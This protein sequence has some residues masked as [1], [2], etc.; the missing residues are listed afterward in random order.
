MPRPIRRCA[1]GARVKFALPIRVRNVANTRE[2]WRSR[3]ARTATE[4]EAVTAGVNISSE[5]DGH[6]WVCLTRVAPRPFDSDGLA[7]SFKAIR[8]Q[9]A[10]LL[11]RDDDTRAGITWLYQQVKGP[12]KT[13][14]VE[15]EIFRKPPKL[16]AYCLSW[17][18]GEECV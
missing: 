1:A 4:R 10:K 8:D 2:H 14:S 13:Y 3:A 12:P 9:L 5:V 6:L 17:R 15:I 16:C 11:G 18:C 7:I